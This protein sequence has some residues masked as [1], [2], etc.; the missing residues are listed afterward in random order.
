MFVLIAAKL[1]DTILYIDLLVQNFW[2][3]K[4]KL[5]ST[6]F[7]IHFQLFRYHHV[8]LKHTLEPKEPFGGGGG[9]QWGLALPTL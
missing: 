3:P 4:L 8:T 5:V 6:V 2:P 9:V 7:Q 1:M